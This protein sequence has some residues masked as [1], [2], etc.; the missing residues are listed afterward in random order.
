M[1]LAKASGAFRSST[2]SLPVT[3]TLQARISSA[4]QVV[5]VG[6]PG[7]AAASPRRHGGPRA[8]QQAQRRFAVMAAAAKRVLVPI[9]NGESSRD[10]DIGGRVHHLCAS[11]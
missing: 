8:Q 3:S 1:L 6:G 4:S 2:A 7:A 11:A 9:G 10:D 5:V